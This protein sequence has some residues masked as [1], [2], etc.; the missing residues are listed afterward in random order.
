MKHETHVSEINNTAHSDRS[1]AHRDA[2]SP[3][4]KPDFLDEKL[5][6]TARARGTSDSIRG[7]RP[8]HGC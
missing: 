6:R 7:I 4:K 3:G 8:T 5:P 2:E 1:A